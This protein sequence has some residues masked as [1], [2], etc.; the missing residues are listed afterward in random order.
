M[1]IPELKLQINIEIHI[2]DGKSRQDVVVLG[3]ARKLRKKAYMH[4]STRSQLLGNTYLPLIDD[5][6]T[7]PV[8]ITNLPGDG[9][10]CLTYG[11]H[12]NHEDI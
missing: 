5:A 9:E 1:S 8:S 12:C 3:E 6:G 4:N 11:K 7:F 2:L 10:T